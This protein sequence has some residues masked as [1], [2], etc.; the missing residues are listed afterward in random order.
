MFGGTMFSDFVNLA[1]VSGIWS[2]L[3]TADDHADV[4]S[5]D[6]QYFME[7]VSIAVRFPSKFDIGLFQF[8]IFLCQNKG[9]SPIISGNRRR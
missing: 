4:S 9:P 2:C 6:L 3:A 8:E 5:I 1:D 7:I